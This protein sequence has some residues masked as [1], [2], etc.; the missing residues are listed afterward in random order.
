ME[1]EVVGREKKLSRAKQF[2]VLENS[3]AARVGYARPILVIGLAALRAYYNGAN[4]TIIKHLFKGL[5]RI[6]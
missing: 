1:G 4:C 3:E 6:I 2:G 5:Y